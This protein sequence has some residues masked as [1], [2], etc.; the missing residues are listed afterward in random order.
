MGSEPC[1]SSKKLGHETSVRGIALQKEEHEP[2]SMGQHRAGEEQVV[3]GVPRPV[4]GGQV[5][6]K[7]NMKFLSLGLSQAAQHCPDQAPAAS[8]LSRLLNH[9][10]MARPG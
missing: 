10:T 6:G 8:L 3:R 5:E 9:V 2:R 4:Q 1:H 7:W